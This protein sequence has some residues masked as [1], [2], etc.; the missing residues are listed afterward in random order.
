MEKFD[1]KREDTLLLIVDIQERLAA[2]M[3]YKDKVVDRTKILIE[4]A[5]EMDMPII[6]TEQ[7]P[8]G[9]GHTVEELMPALEEAEFFTKIS[10]T[11]YTEEVRQALDK[12]GRNKILIA[13]METHVCLFQTARDLIEAGYQVHMVKDAICS[14]TKE[15]YINGLDLMQSMGAVIN[16]TETVVFDLLKEAGSKEFKSLSALIK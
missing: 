13:G 12:L 9:L 14:R 1:L 6:V 15:N 11:A 4:T 2:V 7:Y 5:K 3:E 16:N 10:F 8:K